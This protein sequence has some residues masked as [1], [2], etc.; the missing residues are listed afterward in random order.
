M[1]SYVDFLEESMVLSAA[2]ENSHEERIYPHVVPHSRPRGTWGE[3]VKEVAIP[4]DV[5]D[6][7]VQRY[8]SESWSATGGRSSSGASS[9][10]GTGARS[11]GM[12]SKPLATTRPAH[13]SGA[14]LGG[15]GAG[16]QVPK[17]GG[18]TQR[19]TS[20][21]MR[22]VAGAGATRS[23]AMSSGRARALRLRS[24][25]SLGC[26]SLREV[27]C[28]MSLVMTRCHVGILSTP[29]ARSTLLV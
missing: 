22:G 12:R 4:T 25:G 14:G 19:T 13:A 29:P 28:A 27:W 18:A 23:Q 5:L 17:G 21:A 24:E 26:Q 3:W 1:S 7:I 9:D 20:S 16:L 11:R 2:A 8:D 15:R 10:D 6:V